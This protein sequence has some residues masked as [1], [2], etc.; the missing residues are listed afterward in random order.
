M[1]QIVGFTLIA[2]KMPPKVSLDHP[3][4]ILIPARCWEVL[5]NNEKTDAVAS[6][7]VLRSPYFGKNSATPLLGK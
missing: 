5:L 6:V 7:R 1:E 2:E 4:S 3:H